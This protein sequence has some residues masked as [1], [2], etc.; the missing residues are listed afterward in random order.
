MAQR[1]KA[2]PALLDHAIAALADSPGW[3]RVALTCPDE[4]LRE[5]AFG[6]LAAHIMERLVNPPIA[7]DP[8][9]LRLF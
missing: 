8:D 6:E 1:L 5:Q 2:D 4:R 3:A 9:Q 7:H